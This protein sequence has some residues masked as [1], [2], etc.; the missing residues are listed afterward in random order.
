MTLLEKCRELYPNGRL[1]KDGLPTVC[2]WL[3]EGLNADRE[4]FTHCGDEPCKV[5]WNREFKEAKNEE[6]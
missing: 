5:C 4:E 1:D 6:D 2:P 3:L